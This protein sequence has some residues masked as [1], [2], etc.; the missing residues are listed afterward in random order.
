MTVGFPYK[1]TF[2]QKNG[3]R[4]STANF[5]RASGVGTD[6]TFS[7]LNISDSAGGSG[8][9][10]FILDDDN[11]RPQIVL[12]G[13]HRDQEGVGLQTAKI[14]EDL[15]ANNP[16]VYQELGSAISNKTCK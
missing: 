5:T 6:G 2:S 9:G 11:G 12:G 7:I 13:I 14:L 1:S 3:L 15:K 10:V 16:L 8:S 4:Y